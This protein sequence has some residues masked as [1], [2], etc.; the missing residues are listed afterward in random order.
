[1]N[2][3]KIVIDNPKVKIN[4]IT[5]TGGILFEVECEHLPSE[6]T[7]IFYIEEGTCDGEWAVN[8]ENFNYNVHW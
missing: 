3:P 4:K 2:E 1:M 5:P 7:D 8:N 6:V